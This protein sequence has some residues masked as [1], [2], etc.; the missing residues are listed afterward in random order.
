VGAAPNQVEERNARIRHQRHICIPT[1]NET[2][3]GPYT[4]GQLPE[5]SSHC[6]GIAEDC[7]VIDSYPYSF[8][9]HVY[10]ESIDQIAKTTG[11]AGLR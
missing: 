1:L 7:P 2:D 9:S 4:R 6:F 10:D 5:Q 3:V 11:Y 8:T